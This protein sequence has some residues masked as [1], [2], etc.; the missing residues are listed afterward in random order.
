M[1]KVENETRNLGKILENF[2]HRA[3]SLLSSPFVATYEAFILLKEGSHFN[4]IYSGKDIYASLNKHKFLIF[5]GDGFH[6]FREAIRGYNL[7]K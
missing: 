1:N 2:S 3:I 6:N 5:W 4:D 7:H